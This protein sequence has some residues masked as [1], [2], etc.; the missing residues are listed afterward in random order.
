MWTRSNPV[1]C[2]GS[3]AV[4]LPATRRGAAEGSFEMRGRRGFAAPIAVA[5]VLDVMLTGCGGAKGGSSSATPGAFDGK[6]AFTFATG[7][8][9]SGSLPSAVAKR[10]SAPTQRQR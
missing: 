7:Q 4:A 5:G 9:T 10:E 1:A 3:C 8:D 2:R 6:G